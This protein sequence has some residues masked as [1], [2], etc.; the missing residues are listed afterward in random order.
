MV[1]VASIIQA[2]TSSKRLPQ[3]VLKKLG[4]RSIIE[5]IFQ[6]AKKSKLTGNVIL[7][8]THEEGDIKLIQLAKTNNV[9]FFCGPRDNV[10]ERYIQTSIKKNVDIIVRI[11]AD[12]PFVDPILIDKAITFY[13]N[14]KFDLVFNHISDGNNFWPRGF[15]VE[16]FSLKLLEKISKTNTMLFHEEHVTSYVWENRRNFKIKSVPFDIKDHKISDLKL[17]I[18][19]EEDYE[20]LRVIS[21]YISIDSSV[22]EILSVWRELRKN[23]KV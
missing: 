4:E 13:L 14:N 12:R 17:D 20:K 1:R 18:D 5:W 10:L 16:V 8:T 6:R 7:A 22:E 9:E 19:T 11:C 2:R 3:K 21:K 23:G 15:G